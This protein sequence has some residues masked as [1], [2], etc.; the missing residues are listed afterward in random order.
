MTSG[1]GGGGRRPGGCGRGT[2]RPGAARS[3]L[4]G[5]STTTTPGERSPRT[6]VL[7]ELPAVL[8]L[9]AAHPR[10]AVLTAFALAVAA[11]LAGRPLRE[12]A[13]VA[14]TVLVGQAI[15]G[16]ADDLA[17]RP[18]DTR[19]VPTK[20]LAA[21][22]LDPGTVWFVVVCAVLL[23]VPLSISH[24]PRAGTAYLASV[25]VAL[26]GDRWLHGRPLSF[27]PWA[28]SFALLPAFLAYGGW[29]GVG[30]Q[31]PPEPAM[32]ALAAALGVA[33]HLVL[34]PPGLVHDHEEGERSLPLLL[35][36]KL[37]TPRLLLVAGVL[38]VA[39]VVAILLTG[40]TTGLT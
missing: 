2:A 35:A 36:L 8:L 19:R 33:V 26:L 21:G 34:A 17:D 24:G 4:R 38:A 32:T 29:G 28:V 12:V 13:L 6:R 40:R 27:L 11:A 9:R 14:A 5:M 22:R 31:T 3:I 20:P 7:A 18:R 23:L 15:L 1:C 16:W 10:Q 30:T 39:L 37:G 25:A